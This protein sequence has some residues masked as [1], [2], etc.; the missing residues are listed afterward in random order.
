MRVVQR[1]HVLRFV[2][3]ASLPDAPGRTLSIICSHGTTATPELLQARFG[4]PCSRPGDSEDAAA[5]RVATTLGCVVRGS[6]A[7]PAMPLSRELREGCNAAAPVQYIDREIKHGLFHLVNR[8]IIPPHSDLTAAFAGPT[9]VLHAESVRLLAQNRRGAQARAPHDED[10]YIGVEL[11]DLQPT[12]AGTNAPQSSAPGD[13]GVEGRLDG[14]AEGH[15]REFDQLMDEHSAHYVI[16]RRGRVLEETPEYESFQR[17]YAPLWD[18][19]AAMLLQLEAICKQYAVPLATV[20][21]KKLAALAARD[22]VATG[23]AL[24]AE[25]LLAC[26][27]NIEEVAAVLRQ[28]GRR[29]HGPGG[30]AQAATTIQAH[31]RGYMQRKVRA[32]G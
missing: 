12:Q 9:N 2:L 4:I 30:K 11:D 1:L 28:P 21:G 6:N 17:T 5:V 29:F 23:A 15:A 31:V 27:E 20:D 8:G 18:A 32:S 13:G 26:I 25:L 7:P 24:P 10:P 3:K 16:I 19:L 14:Q 22:D